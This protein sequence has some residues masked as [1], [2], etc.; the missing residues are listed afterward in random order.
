MGR[1]LCKF[2][3]GWNSPFKQPKNITSTLRKD[4]KMYRNDPYIKSNK[5]TTPTKASVKSYQKI[6]FSPDTPEKSIII[7]IQNFKHPKNVPNLYIYGKI[8][9]PPPPGPT[10]THNSLPLP[11]PPLESPMR[12]IR[13]EVGP[14]LS[15][16]L[17][18]LPK[19]W[20][21]LPLTC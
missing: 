21:V 3:K 6:F 14:K 5:V 20:S 18:L 4:P 7:Y 1:T 16:K 15:C 8:R 9:E 19:K 10:H 17:S 12:I 11:P 2:H 13:F